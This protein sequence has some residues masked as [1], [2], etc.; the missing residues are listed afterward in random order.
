MVQK[1]VTDINTP[2]EFTNKHTTKTAGTY[3]L[4]NGPVEFDHDVNRNL[5]VH[6]NPAVRQGML[7]GIG[8]ISVG[9]AAELAK[10]MILNSNN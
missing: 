8:A 5:E 2:I 6:L 7:Q 9:A 1:L 4:N 3:L 10:R